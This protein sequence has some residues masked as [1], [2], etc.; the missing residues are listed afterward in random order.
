MNRHCTFLLLALFIPSLIQAEDPKLILGTWKIDQGWRYGKPVPADS[1]LMKTTW[2][3]TGDKI[4]IKGGPERNKEEPAFYKLTPK[5]KPGSIGF[6]D[7]RPGEDP[8]TERSIPGIYQVTKDTLKICFRKSKN[9]PRP[10]KLESTNEGRE[11]Y[12][13]LKRVKKK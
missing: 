13:I 12:V 3:V 7:I 4:I 6:I 11:T 10:T 8:N 9:R 2:V 1:D 5:K